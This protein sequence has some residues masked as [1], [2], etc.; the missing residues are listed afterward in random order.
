MTTSS[1]AFG[2]GIGHVRGNHTD[3]PSIL[4]SFGVGTFNAQMVAQYAFMIPRTTDP[5][6]QGVIMMVEAVQR[7]L[8]RIG[9]NV[10]VSGILDQA[11]VNALSRVSGPSW[12]GKTWLQL[13]GDISDAIDR[14]VWLGQRSAPLSEYVGIG[15]VPSATTIALVAVGGFLLYKAC[16][17]KR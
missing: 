9:A 7:G 2:S 16:T 15:D 3:V 13:L 10:Q 14:R 4:R 8:Q 1:I 17:K 5:D 11:T 6:A 12:H